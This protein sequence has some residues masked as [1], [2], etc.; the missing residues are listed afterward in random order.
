MIES[1]EVANTETLSP[2]GRLL[3]AAAHLFR[4]QGYDKTT[5]RQIAAAVGIQSGSIFHHFKNKE[6][7][8]LA[9]MQE[10][11]T[12]SLQQMESSIAGLSDVRE[13]LS[14]LL[15]LELLSIN[16][17][18]GEAMGVLF[19][20]WRSL[21]EENQRL[22]LQLRDQYEKH[23][24][25]VL[26][27]AKEAGLVS[28][29]PFILRRFITGITSWTSHWFHSDGDISIRQLADLALAMILKE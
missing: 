4:A 18:S 7:I 14:W 10:T 8:L 19:F 5:V 9:I 22:I 2:R 13:Q 21:S 24:L 12:D 20:E 17:E 28:L 16:G 1:Q 29:D 6:S 27:A 11:I 26:A 23:W 15:Y 25:S 3:K